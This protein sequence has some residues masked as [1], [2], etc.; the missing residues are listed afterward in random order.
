LRAII[1]IDQ[2]SNLVGKPLQ[3]IMQHQHL[4]VDLM[5]SNVYCRIR[6][7]FD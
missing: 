1:A 6:I 2:V 3:P 5:L 4:I 7:L